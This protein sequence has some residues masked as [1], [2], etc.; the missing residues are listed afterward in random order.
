MIRTALPVLLITGLTGF[1]S[2]ELVAYYSFDGSDAADQS[3]KGNHGTVGAS[4]AFNPASPFGTGQALQATGVSGN[5]GLVSV[6]NSSS[7]EGIRHQLSLSAW[8]KAD[9]TVNP[10]W[11]RF[12]R[13]G[14]ESNPGQTWMWNRNASTQDTNMR[15]DTSDGVTGT[16]NMNR[17]RDTDVVLDNQWHQLVFTLDNGNW[18][19]YLDG[20]ASGSGTY[21]HGNGFSNTE[22]MLIAGRGQNMTGFLDDIGVWDHALSPGEA[23]AIQQFASAGTLGYN[24]GKVN[25]LFALTPGQQV[26][27]DGR[28][29]LGVSG[30]A[31]AEGNLEAG[32]G[33][34]AINF[35]GGLGV[36]TIPEPSSGALFLGWILL[37]WRR[38]RP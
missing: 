14:T 33:Q 5:A 1:A 37:L 26:L 22:P 23:R 21:D 11:F 31:G 24:L 12:M 16:F 28:T 17:G 3:P 2:A 32:G 10:D 9:A 7:L 38:M 34:F 20:V 30:L 8:I 29:W 25:Q 15:I 4:M 13:K 6:P 27:I 35:A 18:A 36:M 19:E